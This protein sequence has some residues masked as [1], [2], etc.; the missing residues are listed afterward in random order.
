VLRGAVETL[1]TFRPVLMIVIEARHL[2]K[3][4]ADSRTVVD[5]V[6]D[7]GYS[8]ATL[9]AGRWEPAEV[10]SNRTRNYLFTPS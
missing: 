6:R 10:V 5:F 9:W 8:M 7:H 2:E 1:R 4:G 3:L